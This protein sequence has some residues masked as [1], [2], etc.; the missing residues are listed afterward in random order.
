MPPWSRSLHGPLA[1]IVEPSKRSQ[2]MAGIRSRNTRPEIIVRRTLHAMGFRFRLHGRELP[3]KPDIVMRRWRAVIH[4]HGCFWHGHDCALFRQ[5]SSRVEFW[6]EKI[7]RNRA[8]DT[9]VSLKLDALEWRQLHVWE[10]AL[11]GPERLSP[12]EL[13]DQLQSWLTQGGDKG[14]IR[15][16]PPSADAP[17]RA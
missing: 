10:C 9:Q 6:R 13:C 11:K 1:D 4:V 2:M 5:P 3:G 16:S 7:R 15:G 17:S 12:A 14:E 8:R